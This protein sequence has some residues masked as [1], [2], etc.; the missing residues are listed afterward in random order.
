MARVHLEEPTQE[1][2][3]T[4]FLFF[5][6]G[7]YNNFHRS[8]LSTKNKIAFVERRAKLAKQARGLSQEMLERF[9]RLV[10]KF[11]EMYEWHA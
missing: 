8:K 10:A 9:D 3:S 5:A 2:C 11:K 1:E 6:H 7:K 4:A